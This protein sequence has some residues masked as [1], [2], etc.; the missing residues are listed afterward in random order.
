MKAVDVFLHQRHWDK[1]KSLKDKVNPRGKD[2]MHRYAPSTGANS[3]WAT[4]QNYDVDVFLVEF[5]F[6]FKD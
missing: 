3:Y 6:F 1:L 2:I 5:S 4:K